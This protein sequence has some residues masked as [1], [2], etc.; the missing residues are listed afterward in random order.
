[1]TVTFKE[2]QI[3]IEQDFNQTAL[4]SVVFKVSS[5]PTSRW[6]FTH[7]CFF[8][9]PPR[10]V[11]YGP[12]TFSSCYSYEPI[13]L[14]LSTHAPLTWTL[15][16]KFSFISISFQYHL[17]CWPSISAQIKPPVPR[18]ESHISLTHLLPALS[19]QPT[20]LWNVKQG[21]IFWVNYTHKHSRNKWI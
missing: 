6:N 12:R 14:L 3:K 9:P 15:C 11:F 13:S 19:L 16:Q 20:V 18:G 10:F 8:R 2:E 1:M 17:C 5:F 21:T 4:S 7:L